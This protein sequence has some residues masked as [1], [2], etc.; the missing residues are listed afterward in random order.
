MFVFTLALFVS[1]FTTTISI[2]PPFSSSVY[3]QTFSIIGLIAGVGAKRHRT[4]KCDS[5][6]NERLVI[7]LSS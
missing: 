3:Q 1:P 6:T 7:Y 2:N 4:K 5:C